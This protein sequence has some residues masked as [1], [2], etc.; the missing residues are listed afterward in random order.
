MTKLTEYKKLL[1]MNYNDAVETLLQ[2]YGPALDNYF[3]EKSYAKFL[4]GT[5]KSIGKGNHTR[6]ADGLYVHH[7]DEINYLNLSQYAYIRKYKYPF[8]LHKKERL[9]YCDLIEHAILHVLIAIESTFE[10]GFPGYVAYIRPEIERWYLDEKTPNLNWQKNCYNKAYLEPKEAFEILYKMNNILKENSSKYSNSD[11]DKYEDINSSL[12]MPETL[13]KYYD[14]QRKNLEEMKKRMK[15][16]TQQI[17]SERNKIVEDLNS[18]TD[19]SSRA[20][21]MSAA[22]HIHHYYPLSIER[23]ENFLSGSP[24]K[25]YSELSFQEFDT[26]M[27]KYRKDEILK[28]LKEDSSEELNNHF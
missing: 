25:H 3:K 24:R 4:E 11:T 8:E 21:I 10:Y 5:N 23:A 22:Y 1:S 19:K 7:I 6:T 9:V 13:A 26:K 18:L 2:K 27:K 17:V 15:K 20:D 12:T 28:K 16:R 14:Q